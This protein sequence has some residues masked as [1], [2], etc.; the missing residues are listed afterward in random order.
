MG[1]R[2][3]TQ[4]ATFQG[5]TIILRPD[6]QSLVKVKREE[7]CRERVEREKLSQRRTW[8]RNRQLSTACSASGPQS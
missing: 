1:G 7:S 3:W 8:H 2:V 4:A 6:P 5:T